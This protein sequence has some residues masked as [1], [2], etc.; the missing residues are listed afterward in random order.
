M[1]PSLALRAGLCGAAVVLLPAA[2]LA[3]TL[4]ELPLERG[5]YVRSD[6][7]CRTASNA[8]TAVLSRQ[9]LQWVT[10]YC[11]FDKIE[12]I[13]PA[14]FRVTQ[15]CGDT[16]GTEPATATYEIKSRTAFSFKDSNGWEHAARLCA[17]KDMPQPWRGSDISDLID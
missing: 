8:G 16:S 9:G 10:S 4:G 1:I 3:E 7:T 2:T 5:Y 15:S 13:G 11:I 6:E 14:T 17:Q 12:R